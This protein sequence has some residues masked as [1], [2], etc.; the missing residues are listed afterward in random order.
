MTRL[1]TD[2]TAERPSPPADD[3]FQADFADLGQP[4]VHRRSYEVRA[5]HLGGTKLLIR[6]V[7]DDQAPPGMAIPTDTEPL[8]FHHMVVD[9]TIEMTTTNIDAIE[10]RF[11]EHPH[12]ECVKIADTYQRLVGTPIGRGYSN[13]VKELFG[14]PRGCTHVLALLQA[15]AP[16]VAQARWPMFSLMRTTEGGTGK[17]EQMSPEQRRML[18]RANLNTCHVWAEDGEIMSLVDQGRPVPVPDPILRRMTELDLDPTTWT[19]SPHPR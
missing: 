5:Y 9:V 19:K 4:M 8:R 2:A 11:E 12:L 1:D 13:R 18:S 7:V 3:R 6:G 17:Q 15:L 16:V 10:V 14:G